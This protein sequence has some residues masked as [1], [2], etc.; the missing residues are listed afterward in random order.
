MKYRA[1]IDLSPSREFRSKYCNQQRTERPCIIR[2]G[3]VYDL[4][5]GDYEK[6]AKFFE[7]AKAL[8]TKEAKK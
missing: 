1:K 6:Y 8:V 7:P 5:K 4:E 3:E 2:R